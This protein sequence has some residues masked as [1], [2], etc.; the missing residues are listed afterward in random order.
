MHANPNRAEP[1]TDGVSCPENR[2]CWVTINQNHATNTNIENAADAFDV[3]HIE[4]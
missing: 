2:T 4:P 3:E 1:L